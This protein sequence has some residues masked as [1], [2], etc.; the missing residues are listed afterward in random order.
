M[1][2]LPDETVRDADRLARI[3]IGPRRMSVFRTP[4]R[5]ALEQHDYV[6]GQKVN[7]ELVGGGFSQQAWALRP[8][9][10]KVDAWVRTS[11]SSVLEVHPELSFATMAGA[12]LATRKSSYAGF[13]QRQNLLTANGIVLPPDLGI[14]GELGGVDDVLDAA[15]AAW[16]ARR[17]ARGE[18]RSVP[19]RPEHFSDGI[20]CAIWF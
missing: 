7:R 6:A 10:L 17:Y 11:T 19:D 5:R 16:S 1:G 18:A 14:A 15:A 3:V 8:K 9:I 12:P 20:D 2:R 13:Q 4:T